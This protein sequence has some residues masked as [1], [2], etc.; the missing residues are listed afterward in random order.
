[1]NTT[2]WQEVIADYATV[3]GSL[4]LL[5]DTECFFLHGPLTSLGERFCAGVVGEVRATTPALA[6]APVRLVP[7]ALGDDAGALGAASLAMESWVPA[8]AA[9][10]A[11]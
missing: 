5:L 4:Q 3:I 9:N 1:M 6:E 7:S 2:A 10:V 11:A 8:V